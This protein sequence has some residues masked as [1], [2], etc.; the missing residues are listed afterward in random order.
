MDQLSLIWSTA[1]PIGP[2]GPDWLPAGHVGVVVVPLSVS[3]RILNSTVLLRVSEKCWN[4]FIQFSNVNGYRTPEPF[5][6]FRWKK[7]P[8]IQNVI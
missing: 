3:R 6:E 4:N 5:E 1:R 2:M 7:L 8:E